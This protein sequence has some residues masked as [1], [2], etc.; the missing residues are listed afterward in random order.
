MTLATQTWRVSPKYNITCASASTM[1]ATELVVGL[2]AMFDAEDTAG[3][4]YWSY[5]EAVTGANNHIILRRK[6][7]PGGTLGTFRAVVFGTTSGTPNAANMLHATAATIN[8][9]YVASSEDCNQ[10]TVTNSVSAGALLSGKYV[11]GCSIITAASSMGSQHAP[12]CML[13]ESDACCYIAI[14]SSAVANYGCILGVGEIMER[15][16]GTSIWGFVSS[17]S[18][19]VGTDLLNESSTA[20]SMN[21]GILTTTQT[22]ASGGY[23]NGGARAVG[24]ALGAVDAAQYS[25]LQ[26]FTSSYAC[27][28]PILICDKPV[29]TYNPTLVG[30]LRQ[31]RLA[32]MVC[33][34]LAVK[35]A[36]GT[37]VGYNINAGFS[38][39]GHGM[40]FDQS[41]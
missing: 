37:L 26:D 20:A 22:S 8:C 38:A 1:T 4:N 7:S 25:V 14:V 40:F 31:A 30:T 10:N 16:D 5:A 41:P 36:A 6:G 23:Y 33:G 9:F 24:R 21:V 2:K 35:N 11:P 17:R 15:Y 18:M 29:A 34:Q 27:I 13:I 39:F 12:K 28:H 32:N 3:T 19:S